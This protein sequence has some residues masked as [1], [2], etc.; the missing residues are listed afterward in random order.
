MYTSYP[1]LFFTFLTWRY[2]RNRTTPIQGNV[3]LKDGILPSGKHC[4][5]QVL[6]VKERGLCLTARPVSW[7]RILVS[8]KTSFLGGVKQAVKAGQSL[9]KFSLFLSQEH[10][11]YWLFTSHSVFDDRQKTDN[12]S[13]EPWF[14]VVRRKAWSVLVGFGELPICGWAVLTQTMQLL[15][16]SLLLRSVTKK[17][18]TSSKMQM[19]F[20]LHDNAKRKP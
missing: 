15:C 5:F 2:E 12:G 18:C 20:S 13:S 3:E 16:R 11:R 8:R 10:T 9:S 14:G 17:H 19:L 4:L 6:Y 7:A 1:R